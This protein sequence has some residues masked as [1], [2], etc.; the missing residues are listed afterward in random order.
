MQQQVVIE[1]PQGLQALIALG[2]GVAAAKSWGTAPNA[3]EAFVGLWL[4][5]IL[6][7]AE[8]RNSLA[9]VENQVQATVSGE[10]APPD[11][12]VARADQSWLTLADRQLLDRVLQQF[13]DFVAGLQAETG[14]QP[15][16][17]LRLSVQLPSATRN[18][19]ALGAG[20]MVALVAVAVGT[21]T[22][23]YI[24]T[25]V[26][27]WWREKSRSNTAVDIMGHCS[28]RA[29]EISEQAQEEKRP[30]TDAERTELQTCERLG[31]EAIRN[32]TTPTPKG[33]LFGG[34]DSTTVILAAAAL[35]AVLLL[36]RK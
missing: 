34:I 15:P 17:R 19:A 36:T 20:V 18:T 24:S 27:D 16:N 35:G 13:T 4:G 28:E 5:N 22:L 3:R 31:S 12:S 8:L 25:K 2:R 6:A 1:C 30:L 10:V 11:A 29:Q 32:L 7:Q 23:G 26:I 33:S 21:P 9:I 14:E